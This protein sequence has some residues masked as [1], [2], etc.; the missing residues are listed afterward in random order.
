MDPISIRAMCL[1]LASEFGSADVPEL[2][3][4]ATELWDWVTCWDDGDEGDGFTVV[5]TPEPLVS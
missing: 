5:F 1:D 4:V 3:T 2:L